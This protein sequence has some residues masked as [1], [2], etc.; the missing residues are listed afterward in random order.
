M[1]ITERRPGAFEIRITHKL[2]SKAHY[3]TASSREEAETYQKHL[4][5]LLGQG[6]I[7]PELI[8]TKPEAGLV[9]SVKL[10]VVIG[11]Y[12]SQPLSPS[13]TVTATWLRKHVPA[14]EL[15]GIT[16]RWTDQWVEKMKREE[17]TSPSTIRKRVQCLAR[18]IDWH[19]RST[20]S[21][22]S[23]PLRTLPKGYS[24]Y[25]NED[26]DEGGVY[27]EDIERDRRLH[28]GEHELVANAISGAWLNDKRQRPAV[29]RDSR[30][31]LLLWQQAPET[32]LRL[33]ESFTLTWAQV[34]FD[35][36]TI[37]VLKRRA[38]TRVARMIPM[39]P[40]CF[41]LLQTQRENIPA[42]E[43]RVFP[44]IWDGST[45]QRDLTKT[46]TRL[47]QRLNAA[48]DY[49][50]TQGLVFHDLRHEATCRFMEMKDSK[51]NWLYRAEEV[52]KITGHRNDRTFMRYL[53]LRGSDLGNR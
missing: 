51:G 32:A 25:S 21:N 31:I 5:H 11:G 34:R 14:M 24:S 1:A 8:E 22:R 20:N 17:H 10:T 26:V 46:S 19:L 45:D 37:H 39:T 7:P 16:A 18:V 48:I 13:D 53:S 29:T 9:Q 12:L 28:E 27:R 6:V 33:R 49:T 47:S 38:K 52:R 15:D 41:Q 44:Q 40:R 35:Q 4:R 50:N 36:R 30:D 23:N 2:L 43:S 3:F 42:E